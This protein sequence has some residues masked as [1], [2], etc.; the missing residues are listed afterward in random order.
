[1]SDVI[2]PLDE[3]KP[4]RGAELMLE[5]LE[6]EGVEYVFGNPGTTELPL[7]DA[8]VGKPDIEYIWGLQE[9]S[10]VAMADGYAQASGK[11]GFIN[12]HTAGGLG[13]AMGNLL[14]AAASYTPL[15]VTAG[16][17]DSRHTL[18]D[19][20]LFGDLVKLAT[21]AVKWAQEVTSADHLPVLVRRAF[22][23]CNAAP[24]GPCFLS[25]PMDVMEEM[26]TAST[27]RPSN[28]D[29][30]SVGGSLDELADYL[31]SV[32]LGRVCI[33]AGDEITQSGASKETVELAEALGAPV[34]GSS[35]PARIPYPTS[36]P[37][38]RGN[39]PPKASE[40]AA[41]LKNYDC[42]FALGGKSLITILY[43]EDS[44]VPKGCDVYQLSSDVRDLA[45]TYPS[46]LSVVGDIKLTLQALVP[47]LRERL[48]GKEREVAALRQAEASRDRTR[49]DGLDARAEAD[50]GLPAI[51]PLLAAREIVRGIGANVPIVDEAIATA[52]HVRS[53]LNSDTSP[54]YSFLRGGALGWGM[55]AAVGFSLGYGRS[56]V[57]SLVGDGAALYSPQAIWTA[58][59]EKLPVTFIILNNREY[60]VLKNFMR[61]QSHYLSVRSNRFLAMDLNDPP[62]DFMALAKSWG[63]EGQTI[64]RAGDIAG[65]VEAA[66]KSGKPNLIEIMITT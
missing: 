14:N 47:K 11:P 65:A 3:I 57:V 15:V 9:A 34:Y 50:L 53:F 59:Y 29:R 10:V 12:L 25:L 26:S 8:L 62:I 42:L 48:I 38:W 37:Q 39:M 56:P 30:K 49:R 35:W 52:A 63:V 32:P 4:R 55:P 43:T 58:A 20:L 54:Q 2:T 18:T 21:P 13:H 64:T 33:I 1:M 24:A 7:M 40:I 36:H 27:L 16:Q 5:V 44:A 17:Q 46:P 19:P 23:D 51:T 61:G 22:H 66:I 6:S 45:R 41:I 31:T 60:N 28:I